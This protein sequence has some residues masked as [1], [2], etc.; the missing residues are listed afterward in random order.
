MGREVSTYIDNGFLKAG[1]YNVDFD[2]ASLSSGIYFYTLKTSSFVETK[3]MM[4]VK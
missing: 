1:T 4:L 3:K 2:G